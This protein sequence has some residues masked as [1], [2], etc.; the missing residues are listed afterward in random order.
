MSNAVDLWPVG[1]I[2]TIVRPGMGEAAVKTNTRLLT[3]LAVCGCGDGCGAGMMTVT[4]KSGRYAYYG[5]AARVKQGPDAYQGRRVTMEMLEGI[6][7][8]AVAEHPTEPERLHA[9]QPP[10]LPLAGT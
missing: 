6:V 2:E 10:S 4:G 7:V 1:S 5:C 9:L 8:D 3:K